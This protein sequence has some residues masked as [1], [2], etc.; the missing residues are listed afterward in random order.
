MK[1][2]LTRDGFIKIIAETYT[3]AWALNG[4]WPVG[5]DFMERD[6]NI[7]RC[8]VDCSILQDE[9]KYEAD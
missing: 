4:I 7:D 8:I 1:V 3:E 6:R 5:V 9:E 2:E